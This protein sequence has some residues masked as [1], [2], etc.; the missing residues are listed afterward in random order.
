MNDTVSR[1]IKLKLKL[2]EFDYTTV[3]KMGKENGNNDGLSR[4]YS[5]TGSEAI[6]HALTGEA[7][8]VDVIPDS[9]EAG[10]TENKRRIKDKSEAA[11]RFK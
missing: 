7:E 1:I 4:M 2:Q 8:E 11:C 3:H 6:V 9:D 5:E 10:N